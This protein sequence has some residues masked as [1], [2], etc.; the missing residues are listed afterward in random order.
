MAR[1]VATAIAPGCHCE[2]S[3]HSDHRSNLERSA[4]R[5]PTRQAVPSSPA[6]P[7]FREMASLPLAMTS[8]GAK[9]GQPAAPYGTNPASAALA[10]RSAYSAAG[11]NVPS[12]TSL[13]GVWRSHRR[14]NLARKAPLLPG[15]TAI[16]PPTSLRGV[17][18]KPPPKQS[19][20]AGTTVPMPYSHSERWLRVRSP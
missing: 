5:L 1:R 11:T 20:A 13:R 3:R 14:S 6:A 17:L 10:Y 15:T 8:K 7:A 19:R 18:R 12:L 16:P 4:P 9:A 2:V